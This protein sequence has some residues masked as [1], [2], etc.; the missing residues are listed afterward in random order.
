MWWHNTYTVNGTRIKSVEAREYGGL[1]IFI[2]HQLDLV[3]VIT[4]GNYRNGKTKQS[5]Q[6]F[7]RYILPSILD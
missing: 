5:E 2:I 4:A 6:I 7:E 1:Y 3:C